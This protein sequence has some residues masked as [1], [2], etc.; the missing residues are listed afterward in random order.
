MV[1]RFDSDLAFIGIMIWLSLLQDVTTKGIAQS[2]ITTTSCLK[3]QFEVFLLFFFFFFIFVVFSA[4]SPEPHGAVGDVDMVD[5]SESP[6]GASWTCRHCTYINKHGREN[7]DMCT[8][9]QS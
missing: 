3:I 2:Q 4:P 7:C 9:P 8:L 5:I 6:S 1:S